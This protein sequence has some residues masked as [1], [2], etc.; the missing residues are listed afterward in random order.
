VRRRF[1]ILFV[2]GIT[3]AAVAGILTARHNV[4]Q[5]YGERPPQLGKIGGLI[6]AY[7]DAPFFPMGQA[8]HVDG[9]DREMAYAV[10]VDPPETVADRYEAIWTSQG[11]DV[12]RE[13]VGDEA[14]IAAGAPGDPWARTLVIT[15][16]AAKETTIVASVREAAELPG[17]PRIPVPSTCTVVGHT[18]GRDQGVHTEIVFLACETYLR[19]IIDY[20][21]GALHGT[22]RENAFDEAGVAGSAYVTYAGRDVEVIVAA[23]QDPE[24]DPPK[25]A[26]TVTWQERR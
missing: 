10:T 9:V 17:D 19:E 4:A 20:Y 6:P 24:A 14:W 2:T 7:P 23:R 18:G 8:L 1:V 11:Y 3:G 15:R 5:A 25:T 22:E 12:S 26:A 21:D 13:M 16:T